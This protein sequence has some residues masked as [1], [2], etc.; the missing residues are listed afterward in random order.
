M[1]QNRLDNNIGK[2]LQEVGESSK[3]LENF[4]AEQS[5][6]IQ[7]IPDVEPVST[8]MPAI[9]QDDGVEASQWV[10]AHIMELSAAYGVAFEGFRKETHVLLMRLDE[11]KAALQNKKFDSSNATPRNRG[12]GKNELKDLK[13]CLNQEVE[14]SRIEGRILNL[15][16]K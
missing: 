4:D 15:T 8:N 10:N 2:Q 3:P 6:Q 1:A 14:G 12:M 13:F 5:M 16:L 7:Q 9:R 11:R